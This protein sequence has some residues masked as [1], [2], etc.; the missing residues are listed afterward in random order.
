MHLISLALP[1]AP[2]ALCSV[3]VHSGFDIT[4]LAFAAA[5]SGLL[6]AAGSRRGGVALMRCQQGGACMP[7][8]ALADHKAAVTGLVLSSSGGG[9]TLTSAGADGKRLT[10]SWG[11]ATGQLHIQAQAEAPRCSFVGLAPASVGEAAVAVAASRG[12]RVS[13]EA[14]GPEVS[15]Q[16]VDKRQGECG[17]MLGGWGGGHVLTDRN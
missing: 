10:Y 8:A 3:A 16:A 2:F 14:A 5:G 4:S 1:A 15:V 13:W 12:G 7:L 6:L 9:A 17:A 11:E